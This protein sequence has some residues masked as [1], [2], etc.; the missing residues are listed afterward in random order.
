MMAVA[1]PLRPG[2]SLAQTRKAGFLPPG[3][4]ANKLPGSKRKV[5]SQDL[6]RMHPLGDERSTELCEMSTYALK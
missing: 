3:S 6:C 1:V 5:K 4:L 2:K